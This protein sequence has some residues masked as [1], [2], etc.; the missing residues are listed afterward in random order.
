MDSRKRHRVS[1]G[2]ETTGTK[3]EEAPPEVPIGAVV[4]QEEAPPA[5]PAGAV[6][7]QEEAPPAMPA[8]AVVQQEEESARQKHKLA[9][10]KQMRCVGCNTTHPCQK[11]FDARDV[12]VY[13]EQGGPDRLGWYYAP[14]GAS[15]HRGV[16]AKQLA[17]ATLLATR[18]IGGDGGGGASGSGSGGGNGTG[19]RDASPNHR[20]KVWAAQEDQLIL[21]SVQQIGCKWQQIAS[22][23]PDRSD[24]AV[25]SRYNRLKEA[26]ALSLASGEA[27]EGEE[28]VPAS[29]GGGGSHA[30]T[31]RCSKCGQPKK[32]HVC[33]VINSGEARP[34]AAAK[35]QDKRFLFWTK[36]EDAVITQSVQELSHRWFQIE[37]RL[38][39]RTAHAIRNRWQRLL[40]LQQEEQ[41]QEPGGS[42]S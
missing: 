38:P 11:W 37:E 27:A 31:Y 39:G 4:K 18:T 35:A 20:K 14:G 8:G 12:D 28:S 7:K 23:L 40:K 41:R 22:M 30:G 1:R 24:D 6:V 29:T 3:Q 19:T 17:A 33:T 36:A 5:M 32:N 9:Q 34:P 42:R 25:R 13:D 21:R 26:E 15:L 2:K 10:L 16:C